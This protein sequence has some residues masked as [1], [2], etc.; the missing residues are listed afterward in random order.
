M[1]KYLLLFLFFFLSVNIFAQQFDFQNYSVRDGL[2][3][4]QVYAM[5]KDSQGYIWTGTQGGGLSRFDGLEFTSF[6]VR[7][8]LS[9]NYVESLFEDKEGNLW[10]GTK[11]GLNKFD[12]LNFQTIP[13][14]ERHSI[15]AITQDPTGFLWVGTDSGIYQYDGK[16]LTNY[17]RANKLSQGRV[18]CF[19]YDKKNTLWIGMSYG[20]YQIKNGKPN[21]FTQRS[22]LL[23]NSVRAIIQDDFGNIWFGTFNGGLQSFDGETFTN[24]RENNDLPSNLILTLHKTADHKIWIGT[25]DKGLATWNPKD[26]TFS[27]LTIDDGLCN[28][29][30]R[31]IVEDDW[32]NLWFGT[33][34]GGISKYAGQQFI[35]FDKSNGLNGNYVYA[36]ARDNA[37]KIWMSASKKGVTTYDGD[38]FEFIDKWFGF[39]DVKCKAIFAD[40]KDR[41]WIGTEGEGLAIIDQDS[42]LYFGEKEG[43]I[44]SWIRDIVKDPLG[45]IWLATT[46][47]ITIVTENDT[48]RNDFSFQRFTRKNSALATNRINALHIDNLGR[49]WFATRSEGLGYFENDSTIISINEENNLPDNAV[50]SLAEDKFGNLWIGTASQGICKIKL[51]EKEDKT[52]QVQTFFNQKNNERLTSDNVYLL[53]FDADDNLWVGSEVGV[54]KVVLDAERNIKEVIRFGR[55]EGFVGIETCQN[56]ALK[57][58]NGDLWFGT[59]NGLTKFNPKSTRNNTIAPLIR[60]T[61]VQLGFEDLRDT[62]YGKWASPK[63]GILNGLKLPWNVNEIA[64]A[65]QGINM[66][67]PEK[68]SYQWKLEGLHNDWRGKTNRDFASFTNLSPGRYTFL[69]RAYNED[70]VTNKEPTKASFIIEAPFWQ[71]LW[72]RLSAISLLFFGVLFFIKNRIA[73]IER[74]AKREK[75][76]LELEKHLLGLE[77][78]ALQLQMNPHFIFNALNS[79]QA[80]ISQKDNKKARYQLAKFS[81]LMRSILENSRAQTIPLEDEIQTLDNYL[82]IECSS[83]G[84]TF[85][86]EV[87]AADDIDIEEVR[88]PP[89]MLQPFV[90]NA[91]IHGVAHLTEHGKVSVHFARKNWTLECTVSDNGIGRTKAKELKSQIDAQHKSAALEVT[92]ERL[93]ILN[94]DSNVGKSLEIIDLKSADD[95]T[96][97]TKV[98]VRLPIFT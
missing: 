37:G 78:K 30:V 35:H 88:I 8:S 90:E 16:Q 79:I 92:Q 91:I 5:I 81:K 19:F 43:L 83:R 48:L 11:N 57:D 85:D 4:S 20:A 15:T 42:F 49:T 46:E 67:N 62:E 23:A 60:I 50:R 40:E 77:Q 54:D 56:A 71:T 47:G 68:I 98:V 22:G 63:G 13:N 9:N 6:T 65:F 86:F 34:G 95:S 53:L 44:G 82:T 97:G 12:G 96:G 29:H 93:D 45:R 66:S 17:T 84:N 70:G 72:F 25:Q 89:M 61:N 87:T 3:Q 55:S 39:K 18:N 94:K 59:I 69:V 33:S 51:Y 26:S 21:L 38:N 10:I 27:S 73:K 2:A 1:K 28:N 58:V 74:K 76:K 24:Y 41:I 64:F 32:G 31:N 75:E 7:D 14:S 36:L 52:F 80:L